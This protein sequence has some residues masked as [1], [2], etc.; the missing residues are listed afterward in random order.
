VLCGLLAACG[1][2]PEPVP[3]AGAASGRFSVG[4]LLGETDG[5]AS[6]AEADP[7]YRLRFPAD[8]G[9][10]PRF[11]SE[12]WYLTL[13]LEDS[14][15]AQY[16]GQFTVFRQAL[17]EVRS[18]GWTDTLSSASPAAP[19]AASQVYLG[20][21]AMTD[22]AAGR[23]RFAE[24]FSRGLAPLA[25]SRAEPFAVWLE[26]WR[27]E[28]QED[29]FLPLRLVAG[30]EA[31]AWDLTLSPGKPRVL[32]GEAGY[33]PKGPGQ[34]SHYYSYSRLP[35]AGTL[36]QGER[37]VTVTGTGWLDREWSTSVLSAG[38]IGWDWFA[39]QLRDGRDLMLFN[40]RREDCS[41]DPFD[42]GVLVHPDGHSEHLP[43][44]RFTL[45]PI[46]EWSP[47]LGDRWRPVDGCR[48]RSWPLAWRVQVDD[49]QFMVRAAVSDQRMLTAV[50]Y[51]E[52][53]VRVLD[54]QGEAELGR[55]YL[56]LTGY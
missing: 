2:D 55:G 15:G 49:E 13:N 26:D 20:H 42:H 27:L 56:E 5:K 36:R 47:A 35:V 31:F 52:G 25:G 28:S 48:A 39:L 24:R 37:T 22:V 4:Q 40:L 44:S 54:A 8:H 7:A 34:A 53:L 38:Q 17:P 12:W 16:G 43:A 30:A 50:R 21:L 10:H 51:W 29:S 32:Q 3:D 11:R 6:Y 46:E 33:S 23:H 9:P 41:R 18:E 45:T 14:T 1:V 19:W